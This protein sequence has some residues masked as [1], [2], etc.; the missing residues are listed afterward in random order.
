LH[1][2]PSSSFL[3]GCCRGYICDKKIIN[4]IN[5]VQAAVPIAIKRIK[6]KKTLRIFFGYPPC[7]REKNVKGIT[8][9]ANPKNMQV[10]MII[11]KALC[12]MVIWF[13]LVFDWMKNG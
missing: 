9:R 5:Q 11:T 8:K 10:P 1:A 13:Q 7:A 3:C 6:L 4:H 2:V 12:E